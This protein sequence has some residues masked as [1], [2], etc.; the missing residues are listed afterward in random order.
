MNTAF[1]KILVKLAPAWAERRATARHNIRVLDGWSQHSGGYAGGSQTRDRRNQAG[2]RSR[3]QDEENLTRNTLTNMRLESMDL[4][5]N[6][7]LCESGVDG[8]VKY[9]GHSVPTARTAAKAS[10]KIQAAQWDKAATDWFT[11]YF[12]NRADASR[13]PGVTFGQHQDYV[14]MAS[15]LTGDMAFVIESDGL[16]P[17]E[18]ERIETPA[19][20]SAD[21]SIVRGVR[22]DG[23]GRW[24]HIY[25]CDRGRGGEVDRA[26]F[27]RVPMANVIFCPWYWRPDQLRGVPGLHSVIDSLRDHEEIHQYTKNKVKHEAML[28][29]K[30]RTGAVKNR[31]GA[32]LLDNGDGSKT[33]VQEVNWGMR[34]R[35][36]GAVDDFQFA[37]GQTPHAQYVPFLEYDGQLIAA[38]MGIPYEVLI[39]LFTNGSY[40]AQRTAR[41][42]FYHLLL[43]E[44]AWRVRVFNQRVWNYHIARAMADGYLPPAP[45]DARGISLF[46]EVSW[47]LPHMLEIDI[48]KE[49]AAQKEQWQLGTGNLEQFA[50]ERQTTREKLLAAKRSDIEAA[51]KIADELNR[52]HP[53]LGLTWRDIINAGGATEKAVLAQQGAKTA[54]EEKP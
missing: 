53:G 7:P 32:R 3:G 20:L 18:G 43:D 34:V 9:L 45:T 30:E 40:T 5:R 42:D 31:P 52:A 23:K 35:V 50:S 22:R 47:S 17:I 36:D 15:W 24:S 8:I 26:S 33:E 38:G 10:D 12:W 29:T 16:V 46:S 49:V 44:H 51:A 21:T 25:V 2:Y 27:Q 11:G 48:G 1:D 6:N 19:K 4:Y 28:F 41:M 37:Q 13:R 39:H 14:E 54:P